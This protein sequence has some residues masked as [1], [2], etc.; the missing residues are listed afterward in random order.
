MMN[1]SKLIPTPTH[2]VALSPISGKSK[3]ATKQTSNTRAGQIF[4][5]LAQSLINSKKH[6]LGAF[7]RRIRAKKGPKVAIKALARKL[8]V[9][10]YNAITKGF[11]YV[12]QGVIM[13]EKQ[14]REQRINFLKKQAERLG[15]QLIINTQ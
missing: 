5:K 11:D 2:T 8:A 15:V 10:F 1:T 7:G 13:Y 6:A 3:N 9:L 4:R 14:Y 12:E